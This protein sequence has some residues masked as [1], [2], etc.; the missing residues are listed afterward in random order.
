MFLTLAADGVSA[1]DLRALNFY[2]R[3]GAE[4]R[5]WARWRSMGVGS[6]FGSWLG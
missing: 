1:L 3:M 5:D 2:T 6:D 4:K